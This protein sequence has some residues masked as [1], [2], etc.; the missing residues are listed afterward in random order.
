[1]SQRESCVVSFQRVAL[2]CKVSLFWM[3]NSP[4]RSKSG[5]ISADN[6]LDNQ[7]QQQR[8]HN[9]DDD[10]NKHNIG[11]P[12]ER[13]VP[14]GGTLHNA[15]CRDTLYGPW[16]TELGV[17]N[18]HVERRKVDR[19]HVNHNHDNSDD[20]NNNIH[21]NADS[22]TSHVQRSMAVSAKELSTGRN[23]YE[24]LKLKTEFVDG[25]SRAQLL[26]NRHIKAPVPPGSSN[27]GV[28]PGGI[29][30]PGASTHV[31][32]GGC[33]RAANPSDS[34]PLPPDN[35]D[36]GGRKDRDLAKI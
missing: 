18:V 26:M 19:K 15:A 13:G 8:E 20:D 16:Q 3:L 34:F 30:I 36:P 32:P 31:A 9:D 11:G 35:T 1:M 21:D 5:G 14:E 4:G 12:E 22:T 33:T 10:D 23:P 28:E 25:T 17:G 27:R 7:Q 29:C 2:F 24:P 6:R